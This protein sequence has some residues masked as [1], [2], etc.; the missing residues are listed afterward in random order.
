MVHDPRHRLISGAKPITFYKRRA[1]GFQR[2]EIN[3]CVQRRKLHA[4][5]RSQASP[6]SAFLRIL[7]CC[8]RHPGRTSAPQSLRWHVIPAGDCG[9]TAYADK[10]TDEYAHGDEYADRHSD[11][12]EHADKYADRHSDEYEHTDEY[13]DRHTHKYEHADEYADRHTDVDNNPNGNPYRPPRHGP[14]TCR[15][16]PDGLQP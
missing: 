2:N 16:L 12:Y 13:A 9:P 15:P 14:C 11:E 3:R 4:I 7:S 8:C 10:H 5:T 1:S 6:S